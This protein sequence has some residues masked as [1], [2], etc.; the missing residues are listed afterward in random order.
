MVAREHVAVEAVQARRAVAA[1][2]KAVAADAEIDDRDGLTVV[3]QAPGQIVGPARIGVGRAGRAVGDRIAE[4]RDGAG[5]GAQHVDFRQREP[6]FI[7]RRPGQVGVRDVIAADAEGGGVGGDVAGLRL[8]RRRAAEA[9]GQIVEGADRQ[10]DRVGD[11]LLTGRQSDADLAA[12]GQGMAVARQRG[13]ARLLR[14]RDGGLEDD[15]RRRA[16]GVGQAHA[17]RLTRRRHAHDLAQ[18]Q[19]ARVL[20]FV[21]G[22]DRH[23]GAGP[24]GGPLRGARHQRGGDQ[25]HHV[26]TSAAGAGAGMS[27]SD[28]P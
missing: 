15:Q 16:E 17:R 28:T 20:Q 14:G 1:A 25:R 24:G 4:N 8:R 5:G 2:Q 22:V 21:F 18:A 12:E 9:D 19:V 7:G 13:A 23:L 26:L 10:V 27:L 11:D 3:A 6:R